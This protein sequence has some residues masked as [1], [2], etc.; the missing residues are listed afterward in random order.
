MM[1]PRFHS[2]GGAGCAVP[3]LQHPYH[4]GENLSLAA[5]AQPQNKSMRRH[6][7]VCISACAMDDQRDGRNVLAGK[8]VE[9][10][11][12]TATTALQ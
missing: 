3:Q 10:F 12:T 9:C 11:N 6:I 1:L 4:K 5:S 7:F 8:D 2:K